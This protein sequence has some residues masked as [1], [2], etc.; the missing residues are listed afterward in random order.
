[1]IDK[2]LK[3]E[4]LSLVLLGDFNPVIF[5]PFWLANKN[6]IREDEAKNA[7]IDVIHNEIVR[8]EIADWLKVEV[9][10]S[11]CEFKTTKSP[12]FE[13][14]KDLAIGIF[15]ILKETPI[16]SLG[17]NHVYDL[18]LLSKENYFKIGNTLTP[19]NIWDDTIN[20]PKLLHLEIYEIE[21]KG[22]LGASRRIRI[23]PS[24]QNSISFGVSININ[25]H[26]Q[27]EEKGAINNLFSTIDKNWNNSFV[28]S[29]IVVDKLFS[30]IDF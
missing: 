2:Y 14:L 4:T 22:I 20:E 26:F 27:L 11:R 3:I 12:Y 15:S 30:K 19:L 21:R 24:D 28:E 7:K 13:P 18:S 16:K 9:N 8:Y 1:M 17:I 5:Q 6:L 25:N 10:K 23:T 29:K